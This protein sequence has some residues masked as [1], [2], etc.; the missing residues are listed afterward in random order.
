MIPHTPSEL[1]HQIVIFGVCPD[2]KPN[3]SPTLDRSHCA[4]ANSDPD[5]VNWGIGMDLLEP[6]S[7]VSGIL[8]KQS[9]GIAGLMLDLSGKFPKHLPKSTSAAR[10]HR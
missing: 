4:V 9:I 10:V 2:P 3:H 6:E 5:R 7:W 1:P 8:S